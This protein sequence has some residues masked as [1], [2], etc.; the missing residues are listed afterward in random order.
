MTKA[1]VQH[2][3]PQS[4]LKRFTFDGSQVH[5]FDKFER[6]QFQSNIKNV[7]AKTRFH[8]LPSEYL[9]QLSANVRSKFAQATDLPEILQSIEGLDSLEERLSFV[10]AQ[11]D[12]LIDDLITQLEVN[13]RWYKEPPQIN[14]LDS[15]G[16]KDLEVIQTTERLFASPRISRDIKPAVVL[17][18][19]IQFV[20]TN[21]YRKD[22]KDFLD[23]STKALGEFFL[24]TLGIEASR[25]QVNAN[26]TDEHVKLLHLIHMQDIDVIGRMAST[27][28]KHIWSFAAN[29]TPKPFVTSDNP[30]V[31]VS[32]KKT[33][34]RSNS[35][36]GSEGIE[37]HLPLSPKY[38]VMLY[39]RTHFSA[40]EQLEGTIIPLAEDNVTYH[41]SVQ[42]NQ[43]DRQVY[44]TSSDF[45]LV[46][47]TCRE[48]PEVCDPN[49][50]RFRVY[51]G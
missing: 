45:E 14:S 32:N 1:K 46:E 31:L 48:H 33:P 7:A 34:Y 30:V 10:E 15:E 27:L 44:S 47:R 39:E 4:Y 17:W 26:I 23:K 16:R 20:R 49:R 24:G 38:A 50:S 40:I 36:Y 6:R 22:L 25:F 51:S 9:D 12:N 3:V 2:Y 35:G 37:I 41:N 29:E 21:R 8:D 28:D 11:I 5:V 13:T 19:A 18:I 43:S 42:I